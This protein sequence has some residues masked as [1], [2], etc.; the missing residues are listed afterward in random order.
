MSTSYQGKTEGSWFIQP[1]HLKRLF[2][3]GRG[4][5]FETILRGCKSELRKSKVDSDGKLALGK[6]I[7]IKDS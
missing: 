3:K 6:A 4:G 2:F 7:A 1:P 5:A